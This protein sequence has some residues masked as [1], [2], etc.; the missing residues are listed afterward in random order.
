MESILSMTFIDYDIIIKNNKLITNELIEYFKDY[1][2]ITII[3][4]SETAQYVENAIGINQGLIFTNHKFL[5]LNDFES[6]F[7]IEKYINEIKYLFIPDFPH[8][9][10]KSDINFTCI[11]LINYL[12]KFNFNGKIF[13][14]QIQ[15]KFNKGKLP[16]EYVYSAETTATVALKIFHNILNFNDFELYGINRGSIYHPDLKLLNFQKPEIH[17][18]MFEEYVKKYENCFSHSFCKGPRIHND[19]PKNI[20]VSFN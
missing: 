17:E 1:N 13:I 16:K 8:T 19:F 2:K 18:K 9:F 14:F 20:N 6:L 5:V 7:G 3:G 10:C 11:D 12:K 4:K 15:N